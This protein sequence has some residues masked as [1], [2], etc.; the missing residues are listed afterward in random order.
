MSSK[1]G[2]GSRASDDESRTA[3]KV[4][5]YTWWRW[6]DVLPFEALQRRPQFALL[7]QIKTLFADRLFVKLFGCDHR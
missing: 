3:V 4:G 7:W 6:L 5:M 2:V 1:A